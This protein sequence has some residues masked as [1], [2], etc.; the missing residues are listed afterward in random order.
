[1]YRYFLLGFILLVF[2]CEKKEVKPHESA[3]SL[4]TVTKD[5][6]LQRQ[7]AAEEIPQNAPQWYMDIPEREGYIYTVANA[8]SK[9]ADIAEDKAEHMARVLMAEKV[10]E[11]KKEAQNSGGAQSEKAQE[12]TQSLNRSIIIKKKR[13]KEGNYWHAFVLLEMKSTSDLK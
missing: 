7:K 6:T 10:A 12:E 4:N 2:S 1:M 11:L 13:I 5:S 9:R 3:D 8:R